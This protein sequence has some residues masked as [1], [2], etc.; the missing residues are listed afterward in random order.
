MILIFWAFFS[1]TAV[2]EDV[3]TDTSSDEWSLPNPLNACS[4]EGL[5]ESIAAWLYTIMIPISAIIFLYAGVMFMFSGGD[6]E[7][8]KKAKRALFWAVVGV[9]IIIIGQGIVIT[10]KS[11]LETT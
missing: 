7:K 5:V 10:I 8:I 2:A 9:G 3:C 1:S 6:E 4:L 11:F